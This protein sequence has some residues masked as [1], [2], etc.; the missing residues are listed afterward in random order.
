MRAVWSNK[1]QQVPLMD[2]R[3]TELSAM[4][5]LASFSPPVTNMR[6]VQCNAMQP[7]H[8]CHRQWWSWAIAL[9]APAIKIESRLFSEK[10]LV[11]FDHNRYMVG[12]KG[13]ETNLRNA[14]I[15]CH[16]NL[17]RLGH[18]QF[19]IS[20]PNC[21]FGLYKC[22]RARFRRRSFNVVVR[23]APPPLLTW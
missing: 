19:T 21:P 23:K 17:L 8:I 4:V 7:P 10:Q 1:S 20:P 14:A 13:G 22:A 16:F 11:W 3:Q 9:P 18:E 15:H 2:S 5:L 12:S 6:W